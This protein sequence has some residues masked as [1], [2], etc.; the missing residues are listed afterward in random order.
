MRIVEKIVLTILVYALIMI[1]GFGAALAYLMVNDFASM[2]MVII[3][4]VLFYTL[5][6]IEEQ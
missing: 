4:F 2:L 1:F 5:G 3:V 6:L